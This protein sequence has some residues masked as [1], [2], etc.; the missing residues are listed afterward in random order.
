M[1]K[2][3]NDQINTILLY[4]DLVMPAFLTAAAA[5]S[6]PMLRNVSIADLFFIIP[7]VLPKW[8]SFHY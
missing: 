8:N 3:Q 7:T 4:L 5:A 6:T 2:G 1:L